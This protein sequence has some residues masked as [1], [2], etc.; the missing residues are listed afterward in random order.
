MKLLTRIPFGKRG[1][2]MIGKRAALFV[3]VMLIAC[4]AFAWQRQ[5]GGADE[6]IALE[7]G[8]LDRWAKG[9]PQG[10]LS[11][12]SDEITYFDPTQETRVDG[13]QA[14]RAAY[15]PFAG[16]FSIPRY[17][18]LNSKVQRHG[19]VAVLSYQIRNYGRA[20]DGTERLINRWNV[21]EVFRRT[22]GQWR[23][24][25]SHFSFTQPEIRQP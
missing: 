21:T 6:V 2:N 12:Y 18:M 19:D 16:K 5:Q 23:T 25:H 20:A 4:G 9:D 14:M 13:V 11:I 17:E 3:P 8:A 15:E 10:F 7:R 24:I 1:E 22:G